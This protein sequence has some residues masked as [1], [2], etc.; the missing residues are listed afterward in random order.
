[1]QLSYLI[2]LCFISTYLSHAYGNERPIGL[3]LCW[4]P[5][6]RTAKPLSDTQ[7]LYCVTCL[8]SSE[9]ERFDIVGHVKDAFVPERYRCLGFCGK[10]SLLVNVLDSSKS[11]GPVLSNSGEGTDYTKSLVYYHV[12]CAHLESSLMDLANRSL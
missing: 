10:P 1:M 5:T 12:Y 8:E 11:K 7:S 4:Q 2:S 9:T 6:K 3:V